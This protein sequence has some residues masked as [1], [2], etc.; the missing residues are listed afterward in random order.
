MTMTTEAKQVQS[1]VSG[2]VRLEGA[3]AAAR[4]RVLE[5][6]RARAAALT[7]R[8][9]LEVTADVDADGTGVLTLHGAVATAL[10]AL[11]ARTEGDERLLPEGA[12]SVLV[13]R[14]EP[15]SPG[16]VIAI[17]DHLTGASDNHPRDDAPLDYRIDYEEAEA[18]LTVRLMGSLFSTSYLMFLVHMQLT[19]GRS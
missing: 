9:P 13:V 8:G 2:T 4:Q 3:Q 17:T 19:Q 15:V 16:R 1:R 12:P 11:E 5:E 6:A 18:R 7:E 14:A 10:R